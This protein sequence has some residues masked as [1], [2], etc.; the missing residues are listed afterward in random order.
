MSHSLGE[1][2][3][4]GV[5]RAHFEYNGTCDTVRARLH[6]AIDGVTDNWRDDNWRFCTCGQSPETVI[7]YSSYGGG[8]YWEG[9]ACFVCMAIT[10]GF[11][12]DGNSTDGHPFPTPNSNNVGPIH[13]PHQDSDLTPR[14]APAT[15]A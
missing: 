10:D 12:P 3:K 14:D 4:D 15:E 7:I 6:E 13:E 2:W 1:V 8:F 11:A 9:K 5:L